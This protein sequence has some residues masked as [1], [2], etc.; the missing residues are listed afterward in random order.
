M[1]KYHRPANVI[2]VEN[3]GGVKKCFNSGTEEISVN[4]INCRMVDVIVCGA[5][6]VF[7]IKM[8]VDFQGENNNNKSADIHL[9]ESEVNVNFHVE[10]ID[11][12]L[13]DFGGEIKY[14]KPGDA[15]DVKNTLC[16]K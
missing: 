4:I 9:L 2:D 7:G 6:N 10:N 3:F 12:K 14:D 15:V 5:N 1:K 11:E 13:V 16:E 8:N